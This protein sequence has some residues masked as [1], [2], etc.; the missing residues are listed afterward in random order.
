ML[1]GGP[2]ATKIL[3]PVSHPAAPTDMLRFALPELEPG[4]YRAE[5]KV[6]SVDGHFTGGSVTFKVVGPSYQGPRR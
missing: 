1:V 5:W 2:R 3:L 6:L 4:V